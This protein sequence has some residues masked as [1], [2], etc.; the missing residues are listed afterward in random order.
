MG[1]STAKATPEIS[2]ILFILEQTYAESKIIIVACLTSWTLCRL[3]FS[4]IWLFLLLGICRTAYQLSIQRAQRSI[5]D[6]SRRYHAQKILGRGETV[7]WVN[8]VLDKVWHLYERPICEHIVRQVNAGLP[9]GQRVVLRS[10]AS[11]ERPLRLNRVRISHYG[12]PGNMILEGEFVVEIRP[13]QAPGFHLV[14][15]ITEPLIDLTVLQSAGRKN[16]NHDLEVQVR[17]FVGA[18][19][20]RLEIDCQGLQPCILQ[21]Q[22]EL[23]GQ[24][25]IDCT[26]KTLSQHHFPFHFAHQ[27]DWRKVVE[28]QIREGLGR[29]F[30]SPLPLPF[31]LGENALVKIMRWLWQ[32][33]RCWD[34]HA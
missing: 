12:K 13:F 27:V 6:E 20:I 19:V 29:A 33:D 16:Q 14:E 3:H 23:Q 17:E 18:G 25:M 15:R 34:M 8:H 30:R 28:M 7:H 26:V 22:I 21:P 11:V 5:R 1:K 2:S 24:P 32:M 31:A 10:L 9:P 4:S